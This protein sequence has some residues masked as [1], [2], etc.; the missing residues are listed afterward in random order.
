MLTPV[1]QFNYQSKRGSELIWH[2]GEDSPYEC[3]LAGAVL[4]SDTIRVRFVRGGVLDDKR[5]QLVDGK[6]GTLPY[7]SWIATKGDEEW[8]HLPNEGQE[9][10][11][12]EPY[13]H[14]F[15]FSSTA[16]RLTH[17]LASDERI[18]GLGEHT[19]DMNKRG[20]AFPI[21]NVD[22]PQLHGPQT[23]SMYTSIP[24]YIGLHVADGRAY[25]ILIDHTGLV[26]MDMGRANE[27][28]ASMTVEGD[29]LV[30]Y[31]FTGPTPA[32]VLR[33]YTELTGRIHLPPR[34][35]V[36]YHQS[37]WDYKSDQEVRDLAARLRERN[38]PCDAIWLDID[39]MD[40]FRSFTWDA[41][42]FPDPAQMALNLHDQGLHLVTILDPG[43][44]VDEDYFVYRQGME[45]DY[46]CRYKDGKIFKGTV[47]PGECVFP[48]FS[49]SE[50]RTWWG[51][52]YQGLLDQGVDGI[53]NDMDEP[54][55]S[56]IPSQPHDL[57]EHPTTMSEDVLH[58]AGGDN[59]TGPDGPPV[60]HKFFHNAYGM[61]MARSTSEGVSRLRPNTRPFV[62]T[63]SG[64]AGVQRY[65]AIWTG[66]NTSAWDHILMAMPMCLNVSMS[67][68]PLVGIDIGGFWNASN[69]ELLVRFA[70]LGALLPF[71]RNHNASG[72]PD[73]EPWAFGEPYES[74]YRNAIEQRYRLLPYLYT[75]FH[76]SS[77][78]GAPIMRPL[79]YHYRQDEEA[80]DVQN[81]FLVGASLLSAP[82]YEQG[83]TSRSVYLPGES[84]FDYW[85]G[86]EYPGSEW[87]DISA[88][89]ERWPLFVR[90]NSIIPTGPLM[91]YTG[92][93]PT[94]PLTFTCYMAGDG[95][96]NY[97]LYE[98]DGSTL[99]Y[100]NGAFAETSISCRVDGDLA[101]V[102]IEEQYS[103]FRPQ[104]EWYE[105]IVF[106][107]GQIR[108][109]RVRAGQGK[110]LIRL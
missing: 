55:I 35:A 48:D 53:W 82:L 23:V 2:A 4:G 77:T 19:G 52:L 21:W 10:A 84:W 18:Y 36:G 86:T 39:Y 104:R 101:V 94:D 37:R 22:P 15:S 106:V 97:T 88:P 62:L 13:L 100:Q 67:G 8:P 73:Q 32:H 31:F 79:Y 103:N 61:E 28:E 27:A 105:I 49:R 44:K 6:P 109:K 63:R 78:S 83:A 42:R 45:R 17:P 108:Q 46:F 33:Q 7:H 87:T 26:D 60:L 9:R 65:A 50:V 72:N 3:L 69:G 40:G 102:E 70:Q 54:A 41:Q 34:W 85:D 30:A 92:Q 43:V 56:S 29:S 93:Q 16:I 95:L 12:L 20:E 99:A 5:Y 76:E 38:H 71:C 58:R 75:L 57:P 68:V 51:N 25:G 24:F 89:L 64:T 90:G 98:D 66:D 1:T 91:Q 14:G 81:E 59:P 47:W 80:S 74:A 110:I 96:A 11:M 107:G